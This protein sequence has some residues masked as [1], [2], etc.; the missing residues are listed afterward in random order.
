M[1]SLSAWPRSAIRTH[2]PWF[3]A[4]QLALFQDGANPEIS[5]EQNDGEQSRGIQIHAAE[6]L[7]DVVLDA[8]ELVEGHGSEGGFEKVA[9][10]GGGDSP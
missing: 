1:C 5:G 7:D 2:Y 9:Q 3:L 10:A 6:L 8:V 4:Q